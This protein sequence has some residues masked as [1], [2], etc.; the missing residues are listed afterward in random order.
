MTTRDKEE[1]IELFD[2]FIKEINCDLDCYECCYSMKSY[3]KEQ[4]ECPV[5]RVRD[6][7]GDKYKNAE[8][9]NR[10]IGKHENS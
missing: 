4:Y 6:M 5:F 10:G 1:L 3:N 2:V 9:W 8:I 7:I